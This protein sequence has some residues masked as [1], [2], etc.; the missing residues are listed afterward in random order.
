M[1]SVLIEP[2]AVVFAS[3]DDERDFYARVADLKEFVYANRHIVLVVPR[4]AAAR[5]HTPAA[6]RARIWDAVRL[7]MSLLARRGAVRELDYCGR[8]ESIS[9]KPVLSREAPAYADDDLWISTLDVLGAA[10]ADP[11]L[12]LRGVY[13]VEPCASCVPQGARALEV[14]HLGVSARLAVIRISGAAPS[15]PTW[16][17]DPCALARVRERRTANPPSGRL[18]VWEDTGHRPTAAAVKVLE[19]FAVHDVVAPL[20]L[21]IGTRERVTG[22]PDRCKLELGAED[23][24]GFFCLRFKLYDGDQL[25]KGIIKTAARQ[26]DELDAVF[27]ATCSIY[28][29]L[30]HDAGLPTD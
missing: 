18:V 4:E 24:A 20:V 17:L 7:A 21:R 16:A 22:R 13:A 11:S 12:E 26:S 25:W 10:L 8:E 1:T 2:S 5:V 23:D 19:S 15:V 28:T 30:C 9:V 3:G 14:V 6:N 29:A 27:A